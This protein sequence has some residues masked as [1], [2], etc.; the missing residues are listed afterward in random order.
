MLCAFEE[1]NFAKKILY[2]ILAHEVVLPF[3]AF[4]AS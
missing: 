2:E 1:L 3:T 4:M